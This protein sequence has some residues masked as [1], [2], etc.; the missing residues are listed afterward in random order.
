MI[1]I[2]TAMYCE[3]KPFI[4]YLGLKKDMKSTKFQVFK[5]DEVVLIISGVGIVSSAVAVSHLLT[6]YKDEVC[7]LFFN[8]GICGVKDENIKTGSIFLCHKIIC[9]DTKRNFYPDIL[10]RHHFNEGVLETF[11]TVVNNEMKQ[12]IEGDLVDME[13]AGAYQAACMFLQPHQ[14]HCIKIVSDLLDG[15]NLTQSKV[16]E[17]IQGSVE[18]IYAWIKIRKDAWCPDIKVLNEE[19]EILLNKIR[20]NFK[21]TTSMDYKLKRLAKQYKI[22]SKNLVD[23]MKPLCT[24]ECKSKNE[25]KRYFAKLKEQFMEL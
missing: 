20:E 16:S 11:S 25:G 1:Y 24:I 18:D 10:F 23:V 8:I 14:I 15:E 2:T 3:A 22:R 4:S 21:L 5:N 6:K 12:E 17:V 13:G 7:N 19:E 9:H